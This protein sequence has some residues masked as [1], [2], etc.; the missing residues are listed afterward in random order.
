MVH[1]ITR[2]LLSFALAFGLIGLRSDPAHALFPCNGPGPGQYVVGMDNSTT[3]P[4]PLCEA[5]ASYADPGQSGYWVERFGAIAWGR[6]S[7]DGPV[8]AWYVNA[9][10]FAEAEN[11]AM[12]ECQRG[13]FS[14]CNL[15]PSVANGSLAIAVAGDGGLYAES[16]ANAGQARRKVMR[17]CRQSSKGCKVERVLDSPAGWVS[18]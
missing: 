14:N 7:S 13:G 3:P 18:Y 8:Y 12:A 16:G 6:D 11:G 2:T 9:S 10:S 17:L 1:G 5:D 4:T 15:G